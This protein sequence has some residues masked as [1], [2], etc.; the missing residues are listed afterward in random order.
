MQWEIS[1]PN[2]KNCSILQGNLKLLL[3]ILSIATTIAP[4]PSQYLVC[5][6]LALLTFWPII[7]QCEDPDWALFVTMN[8]DSVSR[9]YFSNQLSS[10]YSF[11][12]C[13]L[14]LTRGTAFKLMLLPML[15]IR[16]Y[17][18]LKLASKKDVS[19]MPIVS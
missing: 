7:W 17:L 4:F 11:V 1:P 13:L 3:E 8:R 10:V 9:S 6:K 2:F 19:L 16:G 15:Q 14:P 18:M 12:V 5:R